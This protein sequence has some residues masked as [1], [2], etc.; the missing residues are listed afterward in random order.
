MVLFEMAAQFAICLSVMFGVQ[1]KAQSI[2]LNT[3]EQIKTSALKTHKQGQL[4]THTQRPYSFFKKTFFAALSRTL[5][6]HR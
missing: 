1:P 6:H 3:H 5:L 2:Q 4:Y